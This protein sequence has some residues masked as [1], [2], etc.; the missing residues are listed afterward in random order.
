[1]SEEYKLT[2]AAVLQ[3]G[4]G[5]LFFQ[6]RP[7]H[8][9]FRFIQHNPVNYLEKGPAAALADIVPEGRRAATNARRFRFEIRI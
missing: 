7:D 4:S 9:F 8:G 2:T 6:A 5:S 1:M 3:Q